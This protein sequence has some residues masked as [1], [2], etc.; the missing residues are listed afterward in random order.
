MKE[1]DATIAASGGRA[2]AWALINHHECRHLTI[3]TAFS[4]VC[5]ALPSGLPLVLR[6]DATSLM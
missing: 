6:G 4:S 3:I 1:I 5:E 2:I